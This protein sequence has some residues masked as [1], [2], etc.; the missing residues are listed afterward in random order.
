MVVD[1]ASLEM[2]VSA[3]SLG[4]LDAGCCW[5]LPSGGTHPTD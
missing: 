1:A 2:M 4:M 3:A 5:L